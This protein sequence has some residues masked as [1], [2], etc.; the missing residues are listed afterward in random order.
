[1]SGAGRAPWLAILMLFCAVARGQ[2]NPYVYVKM[3]LTVPW[4]LYFVFLGA[5]LIPFVVMIRSRMAEAAARRGRGRPRAAPGPAG[6]G[7]LTG[8]AMD[9][10]VRV[11]LPLVLVVV[12]AVIALFVINAF[13]ATDLMEAERRAGPTLLNR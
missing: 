5:V 6:N 12:F 4:T 8:A 1:M 9:R 13:E 3:P 11:G 2:E 7:R 10:F